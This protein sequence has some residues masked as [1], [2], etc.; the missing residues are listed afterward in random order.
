MKRVIT[1]EKD[2]RSYFAH[3]GEV[4]A[5]ES[6][7][8]V[9]R[10][11]WGQDHLPLTL[12]TSAESAE[13]DGSLW[14]PADGVRMTHIVFLPDEEV[15]QAEGGVLSDLLAEGDGMHQTVTM[16]IGWMIEGELGVEMD[17]SSV[18]WLTAGDL[19]VQNGTR[20]RW[21]N[22]SGKPAVAGFVTLGARRP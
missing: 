9:M 10:L 4:D 15:S 19:I 16:D 3:V 12:P 13:H 11:G 7:G 2:G 20:H 22:R 14:P 8:F 1:G 6:D 18:E 5:I 17:D 21:R